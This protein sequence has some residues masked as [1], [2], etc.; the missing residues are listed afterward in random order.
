MENYKTF[1][2]ERLYLKPTTEDEA[3]FILALLNSPKWLENI[4]DR[5][6]KTLEEA[7]IYIQTKITPQLE[8][9]GYSNYT[10]IRKA[11]KVILGSCGLYDR[12]GLQG[13]DIGFAFLPEHEK[14]GYAFEAANKIKEA[15]FQ[16]FGIS[17]LCAITTQTNLA[18]Q[19]LL[20]K[21]GLKFIKIIRI[22]NDDEDLMYYELDN[23]CL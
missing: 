23:H 4:G 13:I 19:K 21:L 3:S 2:T 8:K 1:E 5:N 10:V 9:L 14:Q 22:P 17:K 12:E 18:S 16:E 11:D 6:V 7:K 20:V 15:A